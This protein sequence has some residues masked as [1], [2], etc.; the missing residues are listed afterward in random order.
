MP[1]IAMAFDLSVPISQRI[2]V[3]VKLAASSTC[4]H[5]SRLID[6]ALHD[7]NENIRGQAVIALKS[8]KSPEITKL[9]GKILSQDSS[10]HVRCCAAIVL[11]S[12]CSEIAVGF[13][14]ERLQTPSEAFHVWAYCVRSL[15]SLRTAKSLNS[16]KIILEDPNMPQEVRNCCHAALT[17][18]DSS[19]LLKMNMSKW[20]NLASFQRMLS[21]TAKKKIHH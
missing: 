16:L 2:G 17:T 19:A 20:S 18:V 21:R 10:V 7:L 9:L 13:L 12:S 1:N 8:C 14:L 15:L 3:L 11:G 5:I 4:D 6:L